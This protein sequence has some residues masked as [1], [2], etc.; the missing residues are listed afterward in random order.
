MI[1][2]LVLMRKVSE[3]FVSMEN[4]VPVLILA[5][6]IAILIKTGKISSALGFVLKWLLYPGIFAFIGCILGFA[7]HMVSV[8]TTH[9]CRC[10]TKAATDSTWLCSSDTLFMDTEI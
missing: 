7:V 3:V 8:M 1:Q 10:N 2:Y 9:L 6:C 5:I 4:I